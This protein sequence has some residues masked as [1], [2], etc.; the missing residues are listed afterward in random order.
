MNRK[1]VVITLVFAMMMAGLVTVSAQVPQ[2]SLSDTTLSPSEK[3]TVYGQDF[4]PNTTVRI[5]LYLPSG[6]TIEGVAYNITDMNGT[7]TTSFITPDSPAGYGYVKVISENITVSKSVYF[8]G[9]GNY[10]ISVNFPDKVYLNETTEITVEAPFL[11]DKNYVTDITITRPDSSELTLYYVLHNGYC[12][13]STVFKDKG[14]YKFFIQIENTPYNTT[15]EITV[16][17]ERETTPPEPTPPQTQN[18][19]EF[20]WHISNNINIFW[21]SVSVDNTTVMNG[22]LYL[23]RPDGKRETLKI[24]N[25]MASFTADKVGVYE[26]QYIYGKRIVRKQ[27]GFNPKLSLTTDVSDEGMVSIHFRVDNQ[28]YTVKATIY[29]KMTKIKDITCQDGEGTYNLPESDSYMV[30]VKLFNMTATSSFTYREDPTFSDVYVDADKDTLWIGGTLVGKYTGKPIKDRSVRI[31]INGM[32]GM[33]VTTDSD[34]KFLTSINIPEDEL[35]RTIYVSLS[36]GDSTVTK[37]VKTEKDFWSAYWIY[38]VVIV[39]L[40][41]GI[42]YKMGYL[43]FLKKSELGETQKAF[44]T[45]FYRGG[46]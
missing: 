19:T 17:E 2:V 12:T 35:G 39:I 32:R 4:N 10:Q 23:Y 15:S 36:S 33:E 40:I 38:I 9:S 5:D 30:K 22:N 24:E 20:S 34:G 28:P 14:T 11:K 31:E 21:V 16:T 27:I 8:I 29:R 41:I 6:V 26:V 7:F 3:I 46:K 25:G 18:T 44:I 42:V 45:K 13:F 1:I 37:S 43:D